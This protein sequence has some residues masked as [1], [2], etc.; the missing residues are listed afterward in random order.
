LLHHLQSKIFRSQ[1]FGSELRFLGLLV[2]F[3]DNPI[4]SFFGTFLE[5]NFAPDTDENERG[6]CD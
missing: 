1:L 5:Y 2:C 4:A 6:C 3:S